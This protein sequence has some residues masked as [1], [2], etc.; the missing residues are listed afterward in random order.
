MKILVADDSKTNLTLISHSLT[1]LGHEVI[2]ANSAEEAIRLF[3]SQRPDLI[4]L[5][6]VMEKMDGF[7]CAKK[8]RALSMEDWIPI[9]FLSSAVD[10]ENIAKGISAGGDDYLTKPYSDIVLSAKIKAM[11]R[12]ANMRQKLYEATVKLNVLSSTDTLT[13][14][15]NR[16]QFDKTLIE[17]FSYSKRHKKLLAL[18]F[19]DLDK[20][21]IVND[22]LGHFIGDMLLTFVAKRMQ[23]CIR[24]E[25]FLARI[26]GDEFAIIISELKNIEESALIAKKIIQTLSEP[27]TI[28]DN[29]I[30]IG[31]SIGI[32][33]YPLVANNLETLL[34]CADFA[35]YSAKKS[36]RNNFQFFSKELEKLRD[37][38]YSEKKEYLNNKEKNK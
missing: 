37:K 34:Q 31:A 15:Y 26:G 10:D 12:I 36:G 5:D 7:T 20:F 1:E 22:T 13:G 18:L 25:D 3:Q 6:V 8:I 38:F 35:M 28:G 24:V 33:C 21:K 30:Q 17:K 32:A 23:A 11:E 19:I 16:L 4:I 27:F 14:L 29:T 2:P 9:I